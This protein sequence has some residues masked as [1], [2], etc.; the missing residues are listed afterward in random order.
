[1]RVLDALEAP[2]D[3]VE[4]VVLEPDGLPRL[5]E[6]SA[7]GALDLGNF[8]EQLVDVIDVVSQLSHHAGALGVG[9]GRPPT[10]PHPALI[11]HDGCPQ[12]TS[13]LGLP[14]A[15]VLFSARHVA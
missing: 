5:P 6:F 10:A 12:A 15:I 2:I 4:A 13:M 14:S 9:H 8:A 11:P 7:V 3:S 1:M